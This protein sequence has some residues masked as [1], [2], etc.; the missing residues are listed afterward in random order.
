MEQRQL[1]KSSR[2]WYFDYLR[3]IAS[4]AV[5]MIH[6]TAQNGDETSVWS[7]DGICHVIWNA[8]SRWG[9]PI[10]VMISGGLFVGGKQTIKDIYQKSILRI[11]VAFVVWSTIY[12]VVSAFRFG[13]TPISVMQAIVNGHYHMWFLYMIVG[14]YI[15]VPIFKKIAENEQIMK[16]YLFLSFVFTILAPT[17][18]NALGIVSQTIRSMAGTAVNNLRLEMLAGFGFYFVLGYYLHNKEIERKHRKF[19]YF[20]GVLSFL[21]TVGGTV[22]LSMWKNEKVYILVDS[23]TPNVALSAMALF[24]FAKYNFK[25]GGIAVQKLSKYSFGV[26]LVHPLILIALKVCFGIHTL[27]VTP[28]VSIPLIAMI[29][30]CVSFAVS[31]VLNYIPIVKKYVV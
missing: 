24:V 26:Y 21:A 19:I 17:A 20:I 18:I 7:I 23:M 16:Y 10:F 5:I 4:F 15:L 12:A 8:A 28:V 6:V 9:V 11:V 1:L 25:S 14:L 22:L 13:G 3:I 29:T 27:W 2:M 30:W 31:A